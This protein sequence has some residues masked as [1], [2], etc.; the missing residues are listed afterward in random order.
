[1]SERKKKAIVVIVDP[2]TLYGQKNDADIEGDTICFGRGIYHLKNW[3]EVDTAILVNAT[4]GSMDETI[5]NLQKSWESFLRIAR[6]KN[7]NNKTHILVDRF[8]FKEGY[9][10]CSTKKEDGNYTSL[11]R[12]NRGKDRITEYVDEK[13]QEFE[14]ATVFTIDDR[15]KDLSS[16][17]SEF[18]FGSIPVISFNLGVPNIMNDYYLADTIHTVCNIDSSKTGIDGVNECLIS[19]RQA[20]NW[21]DR[22]MKDFKR[23]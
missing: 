4:N 17:V 13:A 6:D 21:I 5:I 11:H 2:Y 7:K 1:M 22:H 23:F 8:F 9:V 16:A 20:K 19:Y 18:E 10:S 12:D 15:R 14:I 3:L